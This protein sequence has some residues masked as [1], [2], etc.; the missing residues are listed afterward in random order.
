MYTHKIPGGQYANL[1][2]QYKQLGLTKKWTEIKINEAE[3][4]VVLEYKPKFTPSSK[5]VGCLV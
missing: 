2:F 3:A 1:L 5:I 4:N